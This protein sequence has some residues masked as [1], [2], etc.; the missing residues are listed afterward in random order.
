MTD[1]AGA[2]AAVVTPQQAAPTPAPT[3]I[4][5]LAAAVARVVPEGLTPVSGH[6][7]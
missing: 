1:T 3:R 4:E 6:T 5:I 2:A 7:G